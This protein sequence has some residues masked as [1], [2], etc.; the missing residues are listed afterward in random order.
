MMYVTFRVILRALF[1]VL[2]RVK[3][4]GVE[5]IPVGG[6]VIMCSNHISNI[7]PPFLGA[8]FQRKIY[9]MAKEELFRIPVLG[10]I[11]PRIGAFPVKR[12]GVS[13]ESIKT[14]IQY[15]GDGKMLGIFPEGTRHAKGQAKKGAAVIALRAQAKI[16]P[17]AIVGEYKLFRKMIIRYGEPIDVAQF[18]Q[19]VPPEQDAAE[20]LTEKIMYEINQLLRKEA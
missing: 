13:K 3:A 1:K 12:G 20:L 17:A 16:V 4:E 10:W 19:Q 18:E 9:Y 8:P 2:F 15:L 7:D 11:I 6:P 14:A 5:N